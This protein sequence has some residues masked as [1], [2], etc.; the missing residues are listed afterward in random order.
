MPSSPIPE[1]PTNVRH[2]VL[3]ALACGAIISYLLRVS[4]AP[5]NTTIQRELRLNNVE[6]GDLQSAFFIG[7]IWFQIPVGWLGKRY[8]TRVLLSLLGLLWAGAMVVTATARS[9]PLLYGSRVAQGLAQAGLFPVMILAIRAW[10]PISR[11]GTASS[12]ITSC[13]SVGAVLAN[14]L[15]VRLM[16]PF[17][18]RGTFLI[19]SLIAAVWGLVFWS[20]FRDT[21]KTHASVNRAERDLIAQEPDEV[22]AGTRI[23]TEAKGPPVSTPA[24]FVAMA[25]SFSMWALCIQ[26]FFQAF[27][28]VFFITLFPAFLE[29]AHG[30]RLAGAGDLTMMPLM[31]TVLGSFVG[32]YLLDRILVRTGS[33]WLSRCAVS[34]A[35]LALCVVATLV[36][37]SARTPPLAVACIALGMFF[38]GFAKPAQWAGTMDLT[39]GHSAIGFAVMNISG[40]VGAIVCPMVVG[41]M[42]ERLEKIG[43]NWD[44]VLYLIAGIHLAAAVAW[45]T[46]NPNRPAVRSE[47]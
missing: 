29:K 19:F 14:G 43:G 20:W 18:W 4:I 24:A 13:M 27:G 25:C 35:G 30:V 12:V 16:E 33:R 22:A 32:G 34:A 10:F 28:Y 5:A 44:T 47:A 31:G 3:M 42:F 2:L 39:G 23:A 38:G 45:L 11:R 9:Y 37:T 6:M 17:G 15:T 46:L 36:A 40:N 1:R 8:G 7:Y 26:A 41:R 21:P